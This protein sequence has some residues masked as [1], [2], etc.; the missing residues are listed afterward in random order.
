M[1][2][3]RFF[4]ITILLFISALITLF[5]ARWQI[6]PQ[7]DEAFL[8]LPK[9]FGGY[10]SRD[11]SLSERI[12]EILETEN[13]IM[14]EYARGNEPSIL[15]YLIYAKQTYKTSDPP[16]NCLMGEGRSVTYKTQEVL[17][18]PI[19]DKKVDLKINKLLVEEKENKEIY[20]YWFLAGSEFT[21]S[22]LKQRLKL[23]LG[24]L[25][26]KPLSGGQIR[27]STSVLNNDELEAFLRL[28]GFIQEIIPYLIKL[29]S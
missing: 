13:V 4:V 6:K 9:E 11:V 18:V 29:L 25:K 14:R 10:T 28:K 1:V 12:Y 19:R 26:R 21:N 8:Q 22:Y 23:F 3:R 7:S 16:E 20:V 24:Y 2:D 17:S 5:A 27:I 15:F